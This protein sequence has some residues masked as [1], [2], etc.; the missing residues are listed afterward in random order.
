M[1][2]T[3]TGMP[4]TNPNFRTGPNVAVILVH[5]PKTFTTPKDLETFGAQSRA[6]SGLQTLRIG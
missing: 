6:G 4:A 5:A 2:N 1:L 3:D